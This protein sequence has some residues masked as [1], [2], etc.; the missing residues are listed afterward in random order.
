M[1]SR[2]VRSSR[3]CGRHFVRPAMTDFAMAHRKQQLL[4]VVFSAAEEMFKHST[5]AFIYAALWGRYKLRNSR[6]MHSGH[7]WVL[8]LSYII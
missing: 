5:C 3:L 8:S 4:L 7:S 2:A 6:T 1:N